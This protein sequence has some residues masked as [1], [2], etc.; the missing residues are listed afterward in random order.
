MPEIRRAGSADVPA[1]MEIMTAAHAAMADRSAYITDDA[2][3]VAAH[4]EENGFILLYETER[5]PV[6]FF[7]VCLPGLGPGNLGR[8]L[9]F[10]EE[11][12]LR[13]AIMDSTAVLPAWQGRGIMGALLRAAV[14]LTEPQ[15]P[16]LLG[17]VAPNNIPSRRTFAACGFR[18]QTRIVKPQGQERLLMG[19][20]PRMK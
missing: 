3:Y 9:N 1:I 14:A 15:Y 7:L 12:L 6:G 10:P 8:Y 17:T 11:T 13:T 4:T 19:R 16:Y 18:V 5:R 20:F 2:A